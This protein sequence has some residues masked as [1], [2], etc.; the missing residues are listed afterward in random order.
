MRNKRTSIM[1]WCIILLLTFNSKV[2]AMPQFSESYI[3]DSSILQL[4]QQ[5]LY[6]VK[7]KEPTAAIETRLAALD[8]S[9]LKNG[10]SNDEARKVFWLNMYNGW[11]QIL[12]SRERLKKPAIFK[13]KKITIASKKFSLDDIEHGILRRFRC[14]YSKGYLPS[15]FPG[16][17]IRE[18]SVSTIDYRLHFA[19]NCGA[20]SCPPIAFYNYGNIDRQLD[21][22]TKVFL[23]SET[24][25]D[26][27][28]KTATIS[29]LMDWFAGDFN[30]R[31]GI[32][33]I[34]LKYLSVNIKG[35]KLIY[36]KYN[37]EEQLNNFSE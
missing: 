27:I 35:Y 15:L 31:K 30:G 13:N 17:T 36:R 7:L 29:K 25:I 19:L 37:W 24:K 12:A 32:R 8:Y 21:L 3:I 18:L 23:K 1:G 34:I 4:S 20:K 16:K 26:S 28:A 14:K 5:F 11:F 2:L 10:L 6:A 9:N 33:E 22:A